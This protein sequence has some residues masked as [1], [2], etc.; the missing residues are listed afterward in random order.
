MSEG[1]SLP[2]VER[3]DISEDSDESLDRMDQ[4][5]GDDGT[6]DEQSLDI[7]KIEKGIAKINRVAKTYAAVAEKTKDGDEQCPPDNGEEQCERIETLR[8]P[9]GQR[10][11]L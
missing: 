10:P 11:S 4:S 6:F 7:D 2:I 9:N 8:S 3:I 1:W 5:V